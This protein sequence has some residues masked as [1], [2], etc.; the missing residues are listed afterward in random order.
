M[1]LSHNHFSSPFA[2]STTS[3]KVGI[4]PPGCP[5][6]A[7]ARAREKD[8]VPEQANLFPSRPNAPHGALGLT[9]GACIALSCD[10]G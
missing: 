6:G 9:S 7:A 10:A 4:R 3:K 8:A 1:K 5:A 2:K